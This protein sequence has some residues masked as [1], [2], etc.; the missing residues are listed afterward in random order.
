MFYSKTIQHIGS[1]TL[2]L[3][4]LT[5]L[6]QVVH[7]PGSHRHIRRK[8]GQINAQNIPGREKKKMTVEVLGTYPFFLFGTERR[9]G[10]SV[11]RVGELSWMMPQIW[12]NSL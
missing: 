12:H 7:E 4:F 5:Q 6:G 8:G 1:G 10:R 3:I 9:T 2:Y 11:L